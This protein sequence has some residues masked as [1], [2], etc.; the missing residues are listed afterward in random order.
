MTRATLQQ[1]IE[2]DRLKEIIKK[3]E[4]SLFEAKRELRKF[5]DEMI[6]KRVI[7]NSK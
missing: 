4:E 1:E 2:N 5:E 6:E 3:V 7:L